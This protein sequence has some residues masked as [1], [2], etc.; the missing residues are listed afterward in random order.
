MDGVEMDR[1]IL[2]ISETVFFNLYKE[3]LEKY[4]KD[5]R[6]IVDLYYLDYPKKDLNIIN[7]AKYKYNLNKFKGKY[8][9]KI[10]NELISKI[11]NYD[12]ILFINLFYDDEYFIQ[13]EFAEALKKIEKNITDITATNKSIEDAKTELNAAIETAKTETTNAIKKNSKINSI[14]DE[15]KYIDFSIEEKSI[16]T[17]DAVNKNIAI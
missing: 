14:G 11:K 7:K 1:K 15:L 10:R 12:I 4:A 3:G 8:Y 13:G 17:V 6:D 16:V 9:T 2:V 5:N